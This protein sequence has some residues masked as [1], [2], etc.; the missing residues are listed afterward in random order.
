MAAVDPAD[1]D[2][3]VP[4]LDVQ[5]ILAI[6]RDTEG[7]IG[8]VRK[9][10]PDHPRLDRHGKPYA[11]ENLFS[12]RRR[13]LGSMFPAMAEWL[14]YDSFMTVNAYYRAAPYPNPLTGLPDVWRKEK[15][16]RS[17]TA[18]YAD[19]DSGRPESDEPGAALTWRQAQHAAE[20]LA[21]VGVIP[22]P[23]IMARSG[24]GVYL[25]WLLRDETRPKE[26]PRAWPEKIGLYKALNRALDDRLRTNRLPADT[27]AIDA[28]RVLRVPGSIHR[29]A[30]RRVR[31]V[32]QADERGQG[33]V[34]TLPELAAFLGLA[35]VGG[36]LPDS[37]RSLAKPAQYRK[38]K[39]PGTAPL[40]SLGAKRVNA[41]R[42][43]DLLTIE[44]W[45][46]GFLKRGMK[47]ADGTVSP[48]R[49]FLLTLYANFLRGSGADQ[50]ETLAACRTMAANMKPPYPS[51]PPD[52]DPPIESLVQGEYSTDR[53]RRWGNQ[54][55]CDLLGI[56][57]DVARDLDLLTIKP[58]AVAVEADKARPHQADVIEE[59][60]DF[61][62]QYIERYGRVTARK[63]ANAY[64]AAG[65]IGANHQTANQDLN[66]LGFFAARS[67]GGRPRK[68]PGS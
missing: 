41:L 13:D 6:H 9:P 3:T 11:F 42:A 5:G 38:V 15:Y 27:H 51:D 67:R 52:D 8:F 56:T 57:A 25:L 17:L 36:D 49:R 55:L 31:Y 30:L 65:F 18:C 33:F 19:I 12:I 44:V 47:Y 10:D 58:P 39:K 7:Y 66:A 40:R 14:T 60:R 29:K 63:L 1:R 46:G 61:A 28:A 4:A 54:K 68:A 64:K 21:D 43:Q 45:R 35:S 16:L 37:T 50:A 32:I 24:R 26:L 62:R 23:S 22:Q 20:Y 2:E 53:R 59:R 48:G 34:Y